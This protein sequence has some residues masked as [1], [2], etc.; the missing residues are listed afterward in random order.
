MYIIVESSSKKQIVSKSPWGNCA[1]LCPK[2]QKGK[3]LFHRLL[4]QFKSLL[5]L[6]RQ[7]CCCWSLSPLL[8]AREYRQ[9]EVNGKNITDSTGCTCYIYCCCSVLFF[10]CLQELAAT[11]WEESFS[12]C[13]RQAAKPWQSAENRFTP[14]FFFFFL[15]E[16]GCLF[17][18]CWN[19]IPTYCEQHCHH[20]VMV[21]Y[22]QRIFHTKDSQWTKNAIIGLQH[23][24]RPSAEALPCS[25]IPSRPVPRN[26]DVNVSIYLMAT[27]GIIQ[28]TE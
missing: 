27:I 5:L 12:S 13:G 6:I 25:H 17:V 2:C 28:N 14:F 19:S 24:T 11:C 16:H 15:A 4:T 3:I 21:P 9:P 23:P 1:A 10:T 8:N 18:R 7:Q 26:W 20:F 22:A